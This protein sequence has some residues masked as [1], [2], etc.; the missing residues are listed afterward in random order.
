[1]AFSLVVLC[2]RKKSK[3]RSR[4]KS[5]RNADGEKDPL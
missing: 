5:K 4:S 1:L 3:S 2:P